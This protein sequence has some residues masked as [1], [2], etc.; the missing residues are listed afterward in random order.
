MLWPE[1]GEGGENGSGCGDRCSRGHAKS[2]V[3]AAVPLPQTQFD[4]NFICN[5]QRH[6]GSSFSPQSPLPKLREWTVGQDSHDSQDFPSPPPIV[7]F[8]NLIWES[9][10]PRTLPHRL[11]PFRSSC[12]RL[13]VTKRFWKGI[14]VVSVVEWLHFVVYTAV[15]I[16]ICI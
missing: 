5:C 3:F 15:C 11:W 2:W 16:R 8:I 13:W 4:K 9:R 1:T 12:G 6:R 10:V 7:V 14:L